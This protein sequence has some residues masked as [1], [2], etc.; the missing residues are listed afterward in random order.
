[1]QGMGLSNLH[2]VPQ[3]NDVVPAWHSWPRLDKFA[4]WQDARETSSGAYPLPVQCRPYATVS[5][6]DYFL[7]CH[8]PCHKQG[9]ARFDRDPAPTR[10]SPL[11][12]LWTSQDSLAPWLDCLR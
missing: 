3:V 12:T 9:A 6:I 1:M 10:K 11:A 8:V 2:D 5:V 4:A 7:S